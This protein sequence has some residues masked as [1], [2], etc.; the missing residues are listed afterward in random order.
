[1]AV[2]DNQIKAAINEYFFKNRADF[3]AHKDEIENNSKFYIEDDG[4]GVVTMQ[5]KVLWENSNPT[6]S[7]AGQ[8]VTVEDMTNYDYL[9]FLIKQSTADNL[10]HTQLIKINIS[11][12]N[13]QDIFAISEGSYLRISRRQINF[14]KNKITVG[15][16][17]DGDKF[18]GN[19]SDNSLCIPT[20]II[21]IKLIESPTDIN[22]YASNEN[23][24]LNS[25]F[26]INQRE[27]TSYTNTD[28]AAGIY[29]VDR[30]RLKTNSTATQDNTTLKW[31]F[32]GT[33]EQ[34]IEN[35]EDYQGLR[36][37]ASLKWTSLTGTGIMT[38]NDGVNSTSITLNS[39]NSYAKLTHSVNSNATK[40]V[41]TINATSITPKYCKLEVG[42]Y[43]TLYIPRNP[44]DDLW[45]CQRYYVKVFC[46]G[47]SANFATALAIMPM[48]ILP[49]TLRANPTIIPISYPI[50]CG[51]DT[52]GDYVRYNTIR[53]TF[54][55]IV[56]NQLTALL[57]TGDNATTLNFKQYNIY[58]LKNG[59]VAFDAEMYIS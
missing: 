33:F 18:N 13:K 19:S 53:W 30:W 26:K 1:M 8:E 58:C 34:E 27:N 59:Y 3:E 50:V 49:N 7:F 29:S 56:G 28:T 38:I 55:K 40:L 4:L 16:G 42:E 43:D 5:T 44:S 17:Y 52:N 45:L 47:Q 10:T 37:T 36:V 15:D 32:A 35:F 31:T 2:Q 21:G 14:G 48:F 24:L 22:A 12:N 41:I 46:E 39:N 9:I 23:L 11:T 6:S 25:S 51:M 20:Q 54:K 57:T